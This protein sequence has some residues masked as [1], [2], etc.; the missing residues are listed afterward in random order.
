MFEDIGIL[1]AEAAQEIFEK[2]GAEDDY[3]IQTVGFDC[4]IFGGT[5]RVI[6]RPLSG[7]CLDPEY[8]TDRFTIAFYE[9]FRG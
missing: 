7:F 2:C 3:C 9:H 1:V 6:F 5:N 4:V 8:C